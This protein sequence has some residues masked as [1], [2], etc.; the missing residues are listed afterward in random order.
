VTSSDE[1]V[2]QPGST[3]QRSQAGQSHP[4]ETTNPQQ[5]AEDIETSRRDLGQT[6]EALA[7]KVDVKSQVQQKVAGRKQTLRAAQ[8]Q[9]RDKIAAVGQQARDRRAQLA[10]AGAALVIG[11]VVLW[12]IR[13]N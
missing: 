10:P 7:K 2:N 4:D 11:L 3:T 6:V 9:A 12:L 5:L 13:R 1:T 8:N